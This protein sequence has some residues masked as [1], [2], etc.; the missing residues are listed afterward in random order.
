MQ[1]DVDEFM[2]NG[3]VILRDVIPTHRLDEM[4]ASYEALV[5]KQRVV[6][7]RERGPDDPPGGVWETHQQPRLSHVED[8]IDESTASTAEVWLLESTLG[9]SRRLMRAPEVAVTELMLMC[10]PV[11][12]H[13]GGTGWHRDSHPMGEPPLEGLMLDM[14]ENGPSYDSLVKTR[15]EG[16]PAI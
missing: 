9:V 16:V 12:H 2:E 7:A 11:R 3:Y 1:V 6:W 15:F 10:S 5:D 14:A 4:R 13:P 8:L